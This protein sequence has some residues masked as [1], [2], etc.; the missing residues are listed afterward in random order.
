MVN[1]FEFDHAEEKKEI[2]NTLHSLANGHRPGDALVTSLVDALA[3][4]WPGSLLAT[5]FAPMFVLENVAFP[6]WAMLVS[7]QRPLPCEGS[8]LPLS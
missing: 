2:S 7:N 4:Y 8:A 3:Y 6:E 5:S 1:S